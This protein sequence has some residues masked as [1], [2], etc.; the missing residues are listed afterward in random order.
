MSSYKA[1]R[2]S[3]QQET[4]R[5][6][7]NNTQNVKN[8][9]DIAI[10]SKNPYAMA[11]GAAVKAADKLTGGKSSEMLGK[12]L[13][14]TVNKLP[15]GKKIQKKLNKVNES[16]AGDKAGAA[17]R[18]VNKD[19]SNTSTDK[20]SSIDSGLMD[21]FKKE[22]DKGKE[23]D[24]DVNLSGS[25]SIKKVIIFVLPI[26][27]A[28]FFIL[29]FLT[30][31]IAIDA[32]EMD[33]ALGASTYAGEQTDGSNYKASSKEAEEFYELINEV[34]LDM[35]SD[36]K[37]VEAV[38]IVAV[39]H[40]IHRYDS[41]INYDDMSK[42]K[43]KEIAESMLDGNSYNEEIFKENLKNDIF[44]AYFPE[45][46]EAKR[47]RMAQEVI[48]YARNYKETTD[49]YNKN[50]TCTAQGTC[51]YNI[52]GI[53]TGRATITKEINAS[54]I[55]V[56]LM[57]CKDQGRGTPVAGE[58]LVDFEKYILGVVYGEIGPG[59]DPELYKVQAVVARNYALTRPTAMGGAGGLKLENENGQMILQI[60]NCTE[61]Q[62]YCDPDQ[63]CSTTVDIT[64]ADSTGATIY[65][66]ANTKA[67][68]IKDKL[69]ENS[70]MRSAV[71]SV[72]GQVAVDSSGYLSYIGYVSTVQNRWAK[73]V[74]S[75]YDY[76]QI[77]ISDY[78]LVSK[79]EEHSCNKNGS[80]NCSV[81]SSGP[82]ANWK[83]YEGE[84]INVQLGSSGKT[85][86][87]IGCLA[88]SVSILIAKSGVPTNVAG[89]FNPGTFVTA[90]SRVGGFSSGGLF[91]WWTVE[92][93]APSFKYVGKTSVAGM[94]QSAKLSTLQNLLN[95]GYYV[96]AEVKGDTGE[97]W[98][99]IDGISNGRII[100]MDPGSPSTDLWSQYNWVN[101]SQFNYF[102]VE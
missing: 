34:K 87:S 40:I 44:L 9:A 1:N 54:N 96:V 28:F 2:S 35:Q 46:T 25:G 24:Q 58:Q 47:K 10:A 64:T 49:K 4:E 86:K 80:T 82:Y 55:K 97:H 76:K 48:D 73:L 53:N 8:A 22:K 79:I 92:R 18:I 21:E 13:T 29:L 100:M 30:I 26:S 77:I 7:K 12:E 69:D 51:T 17:A 23:Q 72:L 94:S 90:L 37:Y 74:K 67:Y 19:A 70:E 84:W 62:V 89:D 99:A 63:G 81:A 83:Q 101:T 3:S 15:K 61:D 102:K 68:R 45:Y 52:K 50:N 5:A 41:S 85:I 6:N 20:S 38:R 11:A 93:V 56:R 14:N 39:Y 78:D 75:G 57:N 65:S 27:I 31:F 95:S 88:T 16:G 43:I 42:G 36:G 66:G 59:N 98:V 60:R 91:Q 32:G 33:D 71:N